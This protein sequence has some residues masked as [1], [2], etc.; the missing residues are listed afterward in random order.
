MAIVDSH[1]HLGPCRVFGLNNTVEMLLQYMEENGIDQS[2]VQPFPGAPDARKVHDDIARL[3]ANHARRFFGLA[4]LNPHTDPDAYFKE[5][6]RCVRQLGF[7]AVKLHT[8][9]HAVSPLSQ[10]A[11]V[12]FQA[13][14]Q[15]EDPAMVHTGMGMPFASPA[16]VI[17][18]ARQYPTVPI[19][20]AHA[21][22]AIYTM[23]AYV[24]ATECP[25]IYLE[26]SWC[27][28][29]VIKFVIDKLGA[30]RVMFG[31]DLCV[32]APVEMAK[33]RAIGL[34]GD[35]KAQYLGATAAKVYG[36][37]NP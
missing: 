14:R 26:T 5:V 24:T 36:L 17:P 9:G 15:L 21:G 29:H 16:Q 35:K 31:S 20:L 4:S 3:A 34:E 13:A 23:D 19:I 37:P 1:A 33:G 7:V 6:E 25:N 2:V 18:K 27:T 28:P 11:D 22:Y 32:N 12:V 30:D 8:I 10:D